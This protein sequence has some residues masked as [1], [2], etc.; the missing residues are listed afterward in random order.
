MEN[1][2]SAFKKS[3]SK[4]S[5]IDEMK[6]REKVSKVAKKFSSKSSVSTTSELSELVTGIVM[7][8]SHS[9]LTELAKKHQVEREETTITNAT[10]TVEIAEMIFAQEDEVIEV[11]EEEF[12]AIITQTLT[13]SSSDT[14]LSKEDK[15]IAS[16]AKHIT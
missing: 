3:M 1:V 15:L 4:W 9:V 7:Q 12:S 8:T 14:K 5:N 10:T 11:I 2:K 6:I 13:E 16:T